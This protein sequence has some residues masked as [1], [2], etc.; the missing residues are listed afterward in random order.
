MTKIN[1]INIRICLHTNN[2]CNESKNQN[3]Y[4]KKAD[5]FHLLN[6]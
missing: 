5:V 1:E 6:H 3:K 2:N 4:R